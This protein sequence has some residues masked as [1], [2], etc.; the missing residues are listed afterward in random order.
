MKVK[1]IS[2]KIMFSFSRG[3]ESLENMR[4]Q[5]DRVQEIFKR[6]R[7]SIEH[8]RDKREGENFAIASS[9][10]LL[11]H[12]VSIFWGRSEIEL[13]SKRAQRLR[14]ENRLGYGALF[15]GLAKRRLKQT[16]FIERRKTRERKETNK[17]RIESPRISIYTWNRKFWKIWNYCLPKCP[18]ATSCEIL[19]PRRCRWRIRKPWQFLLKH[20]MVILLSKWTLKRFGN[21]ARS[22]LIKFKDFSFRHY[23]HLRSDVGIESGRKVSVIFLAEIKGTAKL[24]HDLFLKIFVMASWVD[25]SSS[26]WTIWSSNTPPRFP[27]S[28]NTSKNFSRKYFQSK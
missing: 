28:E 2:S 22:F 5:R 21:R 8:K 13:I 17:R 7:N 4:S 15:L 10:C 14:K 24:S 11:E 1:M 9:D 16:A 25:C 6:M 26:G 12:S 19:K 3:K 20:R 23:K 27:T 18:R